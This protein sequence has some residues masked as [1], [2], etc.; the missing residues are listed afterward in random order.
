M[1]SFLVLDNKKLDYKQLF[2]DIDSKILQISK[3]S[4]YNAQYGL[5]DKVNYSN[6]FKLIN[7]KSILTWKLNDSGSLCEFNLKDI[8]GRI[9]SLIFT[10]GFNRNKDSLTG[11]L[12]ENCN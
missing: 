5:T 11:C 3:T 2:L 12:P 9:Q 4:L 7:Y 6:A 10:D 1:L 8:I